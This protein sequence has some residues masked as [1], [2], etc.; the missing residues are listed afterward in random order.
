MRALSAPSSHLCA[1]PNRVQGYGP[2]IDAC[3]E[4]GEAEEGRKY[5]ARL[6]TPRQKATYLI[7]L[8]CPAEAREVAVLAKDADLLESI[9]RNELR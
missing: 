5:V 6:P 2:F 1:A 8:G 3:L 7:R 4:M 9:A